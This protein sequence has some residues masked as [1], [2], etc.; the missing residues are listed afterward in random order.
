[1]LEEVT[2][3]IKNLVEKKSINLMLDTSEITYNKVS[4]DPLRIK[5]VILNIIGNA[6]KFTD[7]GEISTKANIVK[8]GH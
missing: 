2:T 3:V 6:I 5:Q 1:M 4:S 7:S 8:N